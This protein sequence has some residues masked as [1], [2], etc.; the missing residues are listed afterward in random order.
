MIEVPRT[1]GL[2]QPGVE[3]AHVGEKC[4][5]QDSKSH[6]K[7]HMPSYQ[8]KDAREFRPQGMKT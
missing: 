7:F 5:S 3:L 8:N 2:I 4:E 6:Y 1:V